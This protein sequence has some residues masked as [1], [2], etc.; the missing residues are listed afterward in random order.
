MFPSTEDPVP[1]C[2]L[3]AA[4]PA[5]QPSERLSLW[6]AA[7]RT[8]IGSVSSR[9]MLWMAAAW[10]LAAANPSSVAPS[11]ILSPLPVVTLRPTL[12]PPPDNFFFPF[13]PCLVPDE[14]P[15]SLVLSVGCCRSDFCGGACSSIGR[16]PFFL[17]G[18][19]VF[20]QS[21]RFPF[22]FS[23]ELPYHR[24]PCLLGLPVFRLN[25]RFFSPRPDALRRSPWAHGSRRGYL[26]LPPLRW[27][28]NHLVS[29]GICISI[30]RAAVPSYSFASRW[31]V[32]RR[33][34]LSRFQIV[35]P[36]QV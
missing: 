18:L 35:L 13:P 32:S 7:A 25:R 6:G 19:V 31:S 10:C 28:I 36:S 5:P 30:H 11:E 9:S 23:R 27:T 8:T 33:G 15:V 34:A 20:H 29:L 16:F 21:S 1:A 26:L 2:P 14:S 24:L 12:S 4:R 3:S 22:T 17:L